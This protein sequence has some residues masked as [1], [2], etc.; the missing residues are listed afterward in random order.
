[1]VLA[2]T[3]RAALTLAADLKAAGI[4]A[5]Y[6]E[7]LSTVNKGTVAV[8]TGTLS[9]GFEFPS[10][11]FALITHGRITESTKSKKKKKDKNSKEIYSLAELSPGDYVVHSTHGIGIFDGIHKIDAHGIIKDY[12]NLMQLNYDL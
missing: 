2:G 3:E 7:S 9:A 11:E 1:M 10:A 8:T 12:I 5:G 6:M 4:P